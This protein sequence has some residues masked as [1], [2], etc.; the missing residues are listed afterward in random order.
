MVNSGC[1]AALNA[2][3]LCAPTAAG[4]EVGVWQGV[5]IALTSAKSY[6]HAYLDVDVWVELQGPGFSARVYGFWDGDR[7]FRVRVMATQPGRWTWTSGSNQDDSG[8]NGKTGG[9]E[10]R[11]W[12]EAEKQANPNRR[13]IVHATP[14]G[15]A[16]QSADG[17]PFFLVG[18]THWAAY[19]WR[20]PFRGQAPQP[21]YQPGPGIGFEEFVQALK[22]QG[23]NSLG[24]I[25]SFPNWRRDAGGSSVTDDAGVPLR[26]AWTTANGKV[27]AMHSE[28]G[29]MPF[30][31]PGKAKGKPEDCADYD[32]LEPAYWQAMDRKMDWLWDQGFVPYVE[33]VRRDHL[34]S[35]V[36]YHDF[37][38][39]FSRYLLYL[40]ARYGTYNWIFSLLHYDVALSYKAE[41]L[42]AVDRWCRTYGGLPF[43]Q[44]TT[45]MAYDSSLR[46][47]GHVTEFPWLQMHTS[48][49]WNRDHR[50]YARLREQADREPHVPVFN[51]E[52]YYVGFSAASFG[53]P[54]GEIAEVNSDRDNYFGRAQMWGS[55]LSGA[56]AGHLFGASS[57]AGCTTGEV[58][59]PG[60]SEH[61]W[62]PLSYPAHQQMRYLR[63]FVLSES[64][65][66]RDLVVATED[67]HLPT[68]PAA[69]A[70]NLDGWA[71]LMRTPDKALAMLY[72][73][74]LC[75]QP[76]IRNMVP[77]TTYRAQW[78]DPRTG[79][80]SDAAGGPLKANAR[81]EL[82]LPSFPNGQTTTLKNDDWA[83]KLTRIA[84]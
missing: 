71:F 61:F 13:G 18:D 53:R 26:Q 28:D 69:K 20:Y 35:W 16:L 10:A 84:P 5:E 32:R 40:Q 68:S 36:R 24:S 47:I 46:Q 3:L 78:Y 81:G 75:N 63:D 42:A 12:S 51:N 21:G 44:I 6:D 82:A 4:S 58:P 55:V 72:F 73:E 33:T 34:D 66:H 1:V 22:Q 62:V 64:P 7:T 57:W 30:A 43:G 38:R 50:I 41:F 14:N 83:L 52:P 54:A 17:T 70:D 79:R 74:G 19:T 67:L 2:A 77:D 49:N 45:A 37:E 8:L 56:L 76:V 27:M 29:S 11:A 39:S 59:R 65:R 25:A 15:R 23:Y 48:G 31:F 60:F 80:W 9:F